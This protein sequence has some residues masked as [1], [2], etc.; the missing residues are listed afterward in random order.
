MSSRNGRARKP[1]TTAPTAEAVPA[2]HLL[3]QA[4]ADVTD[5]RDS[6]RAECESLRAELTE[7]HE[8]LAYERRRAADAEGKL[9]VMAEQLAASTQLINRT[10]AAADDRP[11]G[12]PH[13]HLAAALGVPEGRPFTL[14]LS[15]DVHGTAGLDAADMLQIA[16]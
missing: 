13:A 2:D 5:E 12:S 14:S 11:A 15:L 3:T 4:I 8:D 1:K 16:E 10:I 7:A 9:A 6:A